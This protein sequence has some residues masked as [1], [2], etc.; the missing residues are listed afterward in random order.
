MI[1]SLIRLALGPALPAYGRPRLRNKLLPALLAIS[2]L[3]A[4]AFAEEVTIAAL[5][6]SL[7]AGYGL[8][9]EQ[10]F[11]PQLQAWLDAHGAEAKVIN[12]GVSGDTTAGGL[13]RLDWTLTP[14]VRALIVGLGGNDVLRGIDPAA[15]RANLTQ[16]LDGAK[17]RG[18]P[19]L[20]IGLTAPGN[21][22]PDYKTAFDAI[23]PDLAAEYGT[24]LHPG[25]YPV[26]RKAGDSAAL[27]DLIQSD[28]LH[29]NEKGVALIV[30]DI[31]PQVL[32]LIKKVTPAS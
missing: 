29:P 27:A 30:E 21:Y 24:L 11:V 12:A 32:E 14:D 9:E 2:F 17:A 15:S 18:L 16:I 3:P 25:F 26:L 5:G 23:Y 8:P 4:P 20:L 6:D 7:I 1:G 28:G 13:A 31:G 10:G 22:G 19:V